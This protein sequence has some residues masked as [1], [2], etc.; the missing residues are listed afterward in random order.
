MKK[1]LFLLILFTGTLIAQTNY[2]PNPGFEDSVNVGWWLNAWGGAAAELFNETG[3]YVISGDISARVAVTTPAQDEIAKVS[4][5]TR[6][7]T[8]L[9]EGELQLTVSARTVSQMYLPFKLSLKCQSAD[10]SRRWYGGEEVYL[11]TAP[12]TVTFIVNPDENY[13]DSVWVRLSCG[14]K[15]GEYI[16]DDVLLTTS[17]PD[18]IPIPD[19]RRLREIVESDFP[20]E[21]FYVGGATQSNYW[22]TPSEEILYREFN[23]TTPANDF[24]QTYIHPEPGVYN[25][26]FADGW[27]PRVREHN[28]VMRMHSPIGPQ[29][30][31]WAKDD[32]RTPEELLQNLEEYVTALCDRYND[33]NDV[34][35]WMDV[36]NETIDANTGEWFGPKPGTDSWENPWTIIGFDTTVAL[37]PPL[38]IK[39][40]FELANQHAPNIKQ[41][42]N[43]HGGMN[44]VAW[45]KV[46]A[47]VQYLRDNGLRVDGI[48]YQGHVRA[49]WE[50]ESNDSG[51]NNLVALG[52]LIDWA[53]ENNLE[54][55]M[56]ENNVFLQGADIGNWQKQAATFRA[57][58]EVLLS[59]TESGIVTWDV[60]MIRDCDGNAAPKTPVLFR[61]D[62]SAK[63]A[64]YAVQEVLENTVGIDEEN[65]K[66]FPDKFILSQNYPNPF[67]PATTISYSLP[68]TNGADTYRQVTVSLQVFNSLG[69]KIA[70]LVNQAQAPG[71]YFVEFDARNLPS[72]VYF[73]T[74]RAGS[75]ISTKKMILLK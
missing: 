21:N 52:D 61:C 48:G 70:T 13:R 28:Q 15:T 19:G 53:H 69:E 30:S 6:G 50:F 31:N 57:I 2:V 25:W 3:D 11:T 58:T 39:R 29:C 12:Q 4:L 46:K 74:L 59:K 14:K 42:I 27:L 26:D 62:G 45:D 20:N 68:A 49:G 64:Y 55:H 9:P 72:G 41:I 5:M 73:Y 40:A 65:E 56:T 33:D 47:L 22:G 16:F 63:P 66:I 37:R 24:K 1:F 10:G 71:N 51:V 23:Y 60:W 36:V 54:F 8:N 43:Q 32:A 35:K 75:F 17:E 38:Y 18:T 67:N 44:D 34:I 7:I